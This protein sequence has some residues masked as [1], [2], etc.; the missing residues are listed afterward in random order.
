MCLCHSGSVGT[1][2]ICGPPSDL[3]EKEYWFTFN[4]AVFCCGL[5]NTELHLDVLLHL[6][7]VT[8]NVVLNNLNLYTQDSD[9]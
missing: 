2:S 3:R 9:Y 4:V 1:G 5:G 7:T 6:Q 8:L